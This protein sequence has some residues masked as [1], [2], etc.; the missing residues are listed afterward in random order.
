MADAPAKDIP[1][2]SVQVEA[3]VRKISYSGKVIEA[4]EIFR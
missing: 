4:D 2:N 1:L 3:L